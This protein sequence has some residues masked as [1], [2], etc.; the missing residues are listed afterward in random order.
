MA[1]DTLDMHILEALA[2]DARV[3]PGQLAVMAGAPVDEVERRVARLTADGVLIKYP[4][5]IN[6]EKTG[7]DTVRAVIEVRVQPERDRGF[8]A[9][10]ARIQQFDEVTS[11]YLMSGAY[12]L[13]VM[14]EAPT[15]Q[16]LAAFVSSKLSP[17]ESVIGTATHFMLKTYKYEGVAFQGNG[18]DTRL[19][20]SP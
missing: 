8:D 15:L 10:A 14:A 13:L 16:R 2:D 18:Q 4:A 11:L 17:I 12:D 19:P 3:T 9:T 1:Y 5:M 7:R 6:W 20:V